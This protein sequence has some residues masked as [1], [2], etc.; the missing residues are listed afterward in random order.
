VRPRA[1]KGALRFKKDDGAPKKGKG[2]G[3]RGRGTT[4]SGTDVRNV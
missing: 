1:R 2:A 3:E 4:G